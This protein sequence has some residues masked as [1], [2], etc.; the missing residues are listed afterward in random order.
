[1]SLL[2]H[3]VTRRYLNSIVANPPHG[4]LL[5]GSA[6]IGKGALANYI[7]ANLLGVELKSI[8]NHPYLQIIDTAGSISIDDIRRLTNFSKL[9]VSGTRVIKRVIIVEHAQNM[10]LEAQSAFLKLLEEPPTDTVIILTADNAQHLLPTIL[11][12][13]VVVRVTK[14]AQPELTTHF[15]GLGYKDKEIARAYAI[16]SGLPGLMSA[17]LGDDTEAPLVNY[18]DKAKQ[19]LGVN[20]FERLLK[21]DQFLKEK[22]DLALLLDALDKVVRALLD[23]AL[24]S[25]N[26]S[27]IIKWHEVSKN[28]IEKQ[29]SL[30]SNPNTKLL[31]TDLVLNL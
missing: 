10:T 20:G 16:S 8:H 7:A 1:M 2:I 15:L 30:R 9:K 25:D 18:I 13:V 19:L 27:Q 29:N 11:S 24:K 21:S 23:N 26:K 28:I 14:P 5:E 22:N 3:P 6:G 31:L 17:L 12:R 4:L